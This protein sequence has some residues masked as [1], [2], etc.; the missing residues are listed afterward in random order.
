MSLDQVVTGL[1]YLI[2]IFVILWI[3]KFVF[4][5]VN[6]GF[7][8]GEQLVK[9]DNFALA[10]VV[11]GYFFGLVFALGGVM[12]GPSSGWVEDVLDIV[13]FGL[14]AIV[15]LNLSAWINDRVILY[16]FQNEKEIIEDRNAGTG[17]I[18]GANHLANGLI[19]S[20]ALSGEG[21][22]L[23][24]AL[25]FWLAGQI[26]L[27]L[28]VFLYNMITPFNI[29]DEI[30]KD[31]VA[32]GVA[33]AGMLVGIGNIVRIGISGDFIGWFDNFSVFFGFLIFGLLLMPVLR[34]ISD[35]LLLPGESLTD[36]LVNQEHPNVGAAAVEAFSY[37][38][39][40]MFLGWVV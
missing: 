28:A 40:S 6:R 37:I 23:F 38:A 32:V 5:F 21:G 8:V 9:K 24:T 34:L 30:E 4:D 14:L 19:I 25:I 16:K 10:L 7:N 35:K 29:H 27:I 33:V 2:A 18:V 22:D 39:A 1:V 31:N 12:S 11:V 15:F 17:I 3:G 20:G 26:A 13:F 36:E